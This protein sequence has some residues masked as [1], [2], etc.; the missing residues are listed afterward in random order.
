M[1]LNEQDIRA[2]CQKILSYSRADQTEV[3]FYGT[4]NALTRFAVNHI[5]Q[6]VLAED[7][8]VS[9]RCVMGKRVGVVGTNE[10]DDAALQRTVDHAIEI[11]RLQPENPEWNSL[12]GPAPL[13]HAP[14]FSE[15][16]ASFTPESRAQA[17]DVIVRLAKERG[18]EAA[19][20]FSTNRQHVAVAN[21]LG[22]WA[23]EPR[24]EAECHAVVM[25][26][27]DGS[28]WT[29]RMSVDAGTF[30]FEEMAREA[31]EKAA[32]SRNPV[33]APIGDYATVLDTYAVADMMQN[34][35]FMGLNAMAQREQQGPFVGRLG[36]PVAVSEFTL[37]NDP[38]NSRTMAASFDFEG[39][40]IQRTT[41]I[42]HGVAKA[43]AY[44]S[45]NAL[46]EGK[47]NTG[48]ALPAPNTF[49]PLAMHLVIEAGD[50]SLE[51]L[52]KGV[53]RGVYVTRFHYT[54]VVHPVKAVFTGMTRDGT[55]LIEHGELT[56]PVKN[57]RF[58]Q[59]VFEALQSVT[60]IG[61]DQR[62]GQDYIAVLAPALRVGSWSFTGVQR[63]V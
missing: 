3:I 38:M 8:Q 49:G 35:L 45:F 30:D 58:V 28:G 22:V 34:L 24:T 12:P 26:D 4:H 37:V 46:L 60:G 31:V 40:P 39:Q 6:N 62:V 47:P 1:Q 20:A 33:E 18:F 57:F 56:Q 59:G 42:D 36:E 10:L 19:G 32:R 13:E 41:I 5:H 25:A 50:S 11:A 17:V 44:D 61:R 53:D 16:T 15:T 51:D 43:V 55:F 2:L 21:S 52:I 23:Y 7:A 14:S 54:N 27:G 29:Q 9:I 63:E 48:N